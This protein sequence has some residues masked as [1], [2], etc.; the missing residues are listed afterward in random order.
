MRILSC[1]IPVVRGIRRTRSML[2]LEMRH[3]HDRPPSEICE[4]SAGPART[5]MLNM[6]RTKEH[7]PALVIII[8]E[9]IYYFSLKSNP[10]GMKM[11]D[12]G[13]VLAQGTRLRLQQQV[14][15]LV[16]QFLLAHWFFVPGQNS[17]VAVTVFYREVHYFR[18]R[19]QPPMVPFNSKLIGGSPTN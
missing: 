13:T 3:S 10:N 6:P 16:S 12:S 11:L 4:V 8:L 15:P 5:S 17:R 7:S 1:D 2:C 9:T 14:S 19:R 18:V